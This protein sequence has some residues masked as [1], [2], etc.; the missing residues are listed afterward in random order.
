LPRLLLIRH[1]ATEWSEARRLQGR[2]DPGLSPLGRA[3]VLAWRLPEVW[4]DAPW[5]S[6]PLRRARETAALLTDAPIATEPRLIEMDWGAFEGRTLVDLR[7]EDP[8]GMAANE[9][10]GLDFRPPGGESPREVAE[11]LR[12]LAAELAEARTPVIAVAHKGILR[13]ALALATGWAMTTKPPVRLAGHH[14]LALICRQGG[15][16]ELAGPPLALTA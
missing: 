11:R 14:A 10:R 12:D 3:E 1:G 8:A 5:L 13:A 15:G 16:L 6:S 2:A 4:N 9:A 7:A